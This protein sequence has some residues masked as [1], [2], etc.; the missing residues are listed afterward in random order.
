[1]AWSTPFTAVDGNAFTAA[2]FNAS[3]RD[4]L[5][6]TAPAKVTTGGALMASVG[7][8][9][10]QPLTVQT[11]LQ[12]NTLSLG[13]GTGSYQSIGL[14]LTIETDTAATIF[15]NVR[16]RG[17][18]NRTLTVAPTVRNVD[19]DTVTHYPTGA[20]GLRFYATSEIAAWGACTR[21]DDLT[22]GLNEI[23]V[24]EIHSPSAQA[25]IMDRSMTV[26]PL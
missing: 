15:Y 21:F 17:T 20:R 10:I 26:I 24:R 11:V 12:T 23:S 22:P 19:T 16:L 5:L 13:Y 9:E 2:Q 14:D 4:N 6:E 1:M 25:T 8:H 18:R 3:V 7:A